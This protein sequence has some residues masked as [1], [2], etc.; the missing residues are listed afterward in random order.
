[1]YLLGVPGRLLFFFCWDAADC[2]VEEEVGI[3]DTCCSSSDLAPKNDVDEEV[4]AISNSQR[5]IIIPL[6]A[7]SN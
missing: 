5:L 1:M 4:A 3:E 6:L 7:C 2:I